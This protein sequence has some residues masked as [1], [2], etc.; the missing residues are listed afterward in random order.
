MLHLF[1]QTKAANVTQQHRLVMNLDAFSPA[2][3]HLSSQ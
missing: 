3:Y 2:P 1:T